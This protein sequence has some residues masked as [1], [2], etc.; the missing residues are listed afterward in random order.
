MTKLQLS[1][2]DGL[3]EVVRGLVAGGHYPS[4]EAYFEELIHRDLERRRLAQVRDEID[5]RLTEA[6]DSGDP[7]Q[8]TSAY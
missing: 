6:L 5:R 4:A 1:L 7:V 3:G 2:P 8:A